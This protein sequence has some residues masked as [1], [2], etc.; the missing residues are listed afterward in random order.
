MTTPAH[1][2]PLAP[3]NEASEEELVVALEEGDAY[4]AA[5]KA[6]ADEDGAVT[7]RADVV[8]EFSGVRFANGRKE[9]PGG[10]TPR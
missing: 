6:M 5:L 4:A 10:R 8:V 3:S 2:P 7:R 1:D 9:E